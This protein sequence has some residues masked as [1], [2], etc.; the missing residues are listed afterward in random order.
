MTGDPFSFIPRWHI[1]SASASSPGG[2]EFS[3]WPRHTCASASEQHRPA[4]GNEKADLQNNREGNK[5]TCL[6]Q[7]KQQQL[8]HK[9]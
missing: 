1:G 5:T 6:H 2:R 9:R 7:R 8:R 4:L 3:P